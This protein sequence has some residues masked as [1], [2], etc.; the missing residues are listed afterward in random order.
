[1]VRVKDLFWD[2]RYENWADI[3][4]QCIISFVILLLSKFNFSVS[5]FD[6]GN[7]AT[8]PTGGE[9]GVGVSYM[10]PRRSYPPKHGISVSTPLKIFSLP[11]LPYRV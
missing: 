1:M 11:Y 8:G 6:L 4:H 3:L 5:R 2:K 9:V 7:K 10:A